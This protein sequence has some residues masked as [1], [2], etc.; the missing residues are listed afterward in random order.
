MNDIEKHKHVKHRILFIKNK[1]K[2]TTI[3]FF[4]PPPKKK[5]AKINTTK[6]FK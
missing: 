3:N 6:Y 4:V 1:Q 2:N 5:K